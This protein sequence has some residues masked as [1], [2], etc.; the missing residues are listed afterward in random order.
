MDFS[1]SYV[2]H[3]PLIIRRKLIYPNL[4]DSDFP[5]QGP[6]EKRGVPIGKHDVM[7]NVY[8]LLTL[9]HYPRVKVQGALD[10]S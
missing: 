8:L 5:T 6:F 9:V 4:T 2:S 1:K 3:H 7:L 10:P